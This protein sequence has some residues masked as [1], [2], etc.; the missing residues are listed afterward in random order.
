MD[1]PVKLRWYFDLV[2]LKRQGYLRD[3]RLFD[4]PEMR[5][6]SDLPVGAARREVSKP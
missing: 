4:T 5:R 6:V 1:E 3:P 2:L